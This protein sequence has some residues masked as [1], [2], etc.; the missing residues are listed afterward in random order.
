MVPVA[1]AQSGCTRLTV[2]MGGIAGC[3]LIVTVVAGDIHPPVIVCT[4]TWY[5]F[6]NKLLLVAEGW[7]VFPL[8]KLYVT[9]LAGTVTVILPDANVQ[10]GC[11]TVAVGADGTGITVIVIVAITPHCPGSGVNVYVVVA[12]LFNAGDQVPVI[13]LVEII[14]NAFS[15]APEQIAGTWVKTGVILELTVTVSVVVAAHCPAPG[16]NV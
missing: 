4:T 15:T 6:G 7:K 14:G 9:P 12:V 5:G 8:S 3:G 2:G 10:V 1:V 11:T 16:V 13:P